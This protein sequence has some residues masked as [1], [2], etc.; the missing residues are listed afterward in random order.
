M[1]AIRIHRT[2]GAE[3][4]AL[5]ELPMPQPAAGEVLIRHR[6][7]GVNFID[8]YHRTGLYKLPLPSGIGLEGAAVV[9]ALGEGVSGFAKGD[10]VAYAGGPLGAYSEYRTIPARWLVKLP[11]AVSDDLAAASMVK[12]L[13]AHYLLYDTYPVKKGDTVLIHAAAGVLFVLSAIEKKATPIPQ[14]LGAALASRSSARTLSSS[15]A[16]E[17]MTLFTVPAWNSP[18]V[19]TADA[20]GSTLRATIHCR[21]TS[22]CSAATACR[23]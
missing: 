14:V 11:E 15:R 23:A 12:G 3:V 1:K 16:V 13:T 6:A 5:D 4:L 22:S 21:A 9:E 7:V 20:S 2:G 10:R 18:T 8:I 17:G 19:T